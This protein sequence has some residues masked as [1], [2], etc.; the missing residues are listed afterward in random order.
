MAYESAHWLAKGH[1]IR[2]CQEPYGSYKEPVLQPCGV[3]LQLI[4]VAVIYWE[5]LCNVS[6]TADNFKLSQL[7][8]YYIHI[9]LNT[10]HTYQLSL[11]IM[12]RFNESFV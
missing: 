2:V 6:G 9:A 5:A 1:V 4:I 12:Q 7:L 11:V 3:D 10:N 8:S